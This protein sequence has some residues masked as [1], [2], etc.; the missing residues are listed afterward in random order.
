MILSFVELYCMPSR[1][2]KSRQT[3][4]WVTIMGPELRFK[5]PLFQEL[6]LRDCPNKTNE[7]MVASQHQ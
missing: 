3:E 5:P 1:L 7:N 4:E 2:C 6:I